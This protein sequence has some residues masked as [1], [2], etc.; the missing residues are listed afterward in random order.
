MNNPQIRKLQR[1]GHS[2]QVVIPVAFAESLR[3]LPGDYLV[4]TCEDGR[5]VLEANS[6]H[7]VRLAAKKAHDPVPTNGDE[8]PRP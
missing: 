6:D 1:L 3:W 2:L 8:V 4:L 7:A 5:I